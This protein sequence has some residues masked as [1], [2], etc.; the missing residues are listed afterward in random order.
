VLVGGKRAQACH[1]PEAA[2]AGKSVLT[3][4]GLATS[5]G[6]HPVQE[7][8]LAEHAFQ[9]GYCTPGMIMNAVALLGEKPNPSD[10]DILTWMDGNI[11]RCCGYPKILQAVRRAAARTGG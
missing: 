3:N 8:F 1:T 11:C 2:L 5:D 4:E 6:L 10:A 7:A 9:C